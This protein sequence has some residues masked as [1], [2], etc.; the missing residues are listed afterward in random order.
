MYFIFT[1]PLL[2][3]YENLK[4]KYNIRNNQMAS[5]THLTDDDFYLDR[6]EGGKILCSNLEGV[7]LILFYADKCA[8]CGDIV[9]DFKK[10]PSIIPGVRFGLVNLYRFRKIYELSKTTTTTLSAVPYMIL[11]VKNIPRLIYD[12]DKTLDGIIDFINN[13][14]PRIKSQDNFINKRENK[15]AAGGNG[16][17]GLDA[18][19]AYTIGRP[20]NIECDKE[21]G[22]CYLSFNDAYKGKVVKENP[23]DNRYAGQDYGH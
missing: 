16:T 1:V 6:G 10:L 14:L 13:V 22:I 2:S 23:D 12:G 9:P 7:A 4:E 17:G 3:L 5:A 19:P 21:K 20:Y 18:I 8:F 11:Y 15:N